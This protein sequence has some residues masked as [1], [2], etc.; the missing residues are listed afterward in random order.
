MIKDS[1]ALLRTRSSHDILKSALTAVRPLELEPTSPSIEIDPE[2]PLLIVDVDEVLALFM[3]GFGRFVATRGYEMRVDRFALFQ[4]IYRLGESECI[5]LPTGRTL[6]DDFFRFA[7]DIDPTPDA[8]HSLRKLAH[9][10]VTIV[11]LTNAPPHAREPRA[12]WLV[13]HG[14]D[15]PMIINQGPKGEAI[16]ALA[17]RTNKPVAFVDDL[18]GNLDS[19]AQAAPQVLRFQLVADPRLRDLAPTAPDR[20]R[21]IDHWPQLYDALARALNVSA[22]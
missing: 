18:I 2:K 14:M 11:I 13:K 9:A 15:Y 22:V 1:P 3:H 7:D 17:A 5:D 21:R 20:H 8:A 19:A 4:N 12:R 6:F 10:G 16:A